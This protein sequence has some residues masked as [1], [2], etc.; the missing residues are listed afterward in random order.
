[1]K[2]SHRLMTLSATVGLM[3][4]GGFFASSASAGTVASAAPKAP[5][6]VSKQISAAGSPAATLCWTGVRDEQPL[7]WFGAP[8]TA[9]QPVVASASEG[10]LHGEGANDAHVYSEGVTVLNSA[11]IVRIHTGW[12]DP[13]N[14]CVH[15][16][17]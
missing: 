1:M 2:K 11:V 9:S 13:L 12:G 10:V 3:A 16:L 4:G 5:V 15:Y 6:L 14:V 8:V 7:T 17:G